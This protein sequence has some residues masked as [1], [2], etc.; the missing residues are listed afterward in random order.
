MFL[1]VPAY[2]SY[3]G[4]RAVKQLCMCVST[5]RQTRWA[6]NGCWNKVFLWWH[7]CDMRPQTGHIVASTPMTLSAQQQQF[8]CECLC[9]GMHACTTALTYLHSYTGTDG[10]TTQKNNDS[11]P[12]YRMRRDI[13]NITGKYECTC[14]P[15][16]LNWSKLSTVLW[17]T[18]KSC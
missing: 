13:M 12:N 7:M 14:G 2:R 6:E 10:W 15:T 18:I 16:T 3:P 1:L 4:Q 8:N 17:T 9:P 11:N 5:E